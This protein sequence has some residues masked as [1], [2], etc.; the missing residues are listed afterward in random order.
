MIVA[1]GAIGLVFSYFQYTLIAKTT[2]KPQPTSESSHLRM[3][4]PKITEVGDLTSYC[5]YRVRAGW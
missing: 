4:D 2:I 1:S 5:G 3:L